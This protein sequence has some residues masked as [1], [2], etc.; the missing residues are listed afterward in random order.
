MPLRVGASLSQTIE[1]EVRRRGYLKV[2]TTI[3]VQNL[4]MI[5]IKLKQGYYVEGLCRDHDRPGLHEYTLG[6]VFAEYDRVQAERAANV[7]A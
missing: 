3:Y 4:P 7:K 2:V 5:F 1:D 6:K